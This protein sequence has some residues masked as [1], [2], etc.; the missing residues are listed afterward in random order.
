MRQ[1]TA[2]QFLADKT[3]G[4]RSE[5]TFIDL[6]A[7]MGGT[8][9]SIGRIPGISDQTPRFSRPKADSENGYCY[10]VSPDI[11]FT[12]PG[13]PKG[14]AALAQV[15]VRKLYREPSKGWIY[16]YLDEQELHRMNVANQFYDVFFVIHVSGLEGLAD[17][18]DWMWVKVDNLKEPVRPLIKREVCEKPTFLIP[19]NLFRP[20]SQLLDRAIHPLVNGHTPFLVACDL[21]MAKLADF[22]LDELSLKQ[23]GLQH[24]R[25]FDFNAI[26]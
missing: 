2:A 20:L 11:L 26:S 22:K 12:L 25:F 7:A 24:A 23:A 14:A 10:A 21:D 8:A 15:K 4:Q 16:V 13:W 1:R 3:K 9:Q 6:I 18:S 17:Y 19:L 5:K